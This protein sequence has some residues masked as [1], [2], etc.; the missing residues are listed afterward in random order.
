MDAYDGISTPT[1]VHS[2][3]DIDTSGHQVKNGELRPPY[4]PSESIETGKQIRG[5]EFSLI[6]LKMVPDII[7]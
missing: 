1:P 3:P 5:E 7:K 6:V 4:Q 2:Y